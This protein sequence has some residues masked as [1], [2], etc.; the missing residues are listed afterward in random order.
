MRTIISETITRKDIETKCSQITIMAKYLNIPTDCIINCL[1]TKSL[2]PS[3]FRDDDTVGSMGFIYNKHGRLK[4]RDF[5]GF[6][7]FG[8]CYDVAAY[9]LEAKEGRKLNIN[10]PSD[11]KVVLRHIYKTLVLNHQDDDINNM[12]IYQ[13]E[14]NR[15]KR[16][17]IE[18][19]PRNWNR[20]D[21]TIWKTWNIDSVFLDS[22]FVYPVDTYYINGIPHY[23]KDNDPCYAYVLGQDKR[24]V[25]LIKLYFPKRNSET[26]QKFITNCNV[27]EGLPN[28]ER[29]N[30]DYIL[31]TKSSK[32]RLSL[33][34][35]INSLFYGGLISVKIGIINVPS[36]VYKLK[37][38]EYDYLVS[39]LKS[40]GKI[41]SLFD[42][43]YT[44]RNG[45]KYLFE[46][47]N[48]PYIFITRGEFSLYDYKAKDFADLHYVYNNE[49][50][51]KF[52]KETLTYIELKYVNFNSV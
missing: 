10:S 43:D 26:E 17:I 11:F 41:I 18:F 51:N 16:T 24:N 8:D 46:K 13:L 15:N 25:C 31:I 34:S 3:V 19:T 21:K 5:G 50:I 14:R 37:E 42:F 33:E 47:Y 39:K 32:D 1:E 27:L 28:L 4:V 12:I 23:V 40:T 49:E 22:H 38:K 2:I 35:H 52:I 29:N 48:I 36:E 30:Y 44:G 7:F 6:G 20:Y 45:A 9:M